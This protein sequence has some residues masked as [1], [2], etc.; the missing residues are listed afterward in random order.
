[1]GKHNV[2]G[3]RADHHLRIKKEEHEQEKKNN[4]KKKKVESL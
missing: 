4:K 1:V 2:G 3:Q